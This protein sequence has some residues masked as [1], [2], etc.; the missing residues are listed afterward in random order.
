MRGIMTIFCN[1]CGKDVECRL[2]NGSEIY[3]HRGDLKDL[4]FWIHDVCGNYVG[5]HHKTDNPTTPLIPP[6]L[7]LDRH[8]F[9]SS[10][11]LGKAPRPERTFVG[12]LT[13]ADVKTL[14]KFHD[15]KLPEFAKGKRLMLRDMVHRDVGLHVFQHATMK[16]GVLL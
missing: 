11:A 13:D 5:C 12:K 8:F 14:E 1:E 2:T 6:S 10:K 9:W 15:I 4:P 3:P 16:Q 7:K